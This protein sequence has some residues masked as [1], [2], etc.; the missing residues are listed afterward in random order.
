MTIIVRVAVVVAVV[1]VASILSRSKEVRALTAWVESFFSLP[2]LY[3]YQY[4]VHCYLLFRWRTCR[5]FFQRCSVCVCVC[6]GSNIF[7]SG[8]ALNP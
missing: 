7:S 1:V 2:A 4:V 6:E 3:M 8:E 5:A